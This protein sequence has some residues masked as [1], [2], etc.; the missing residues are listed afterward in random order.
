[1]TVH[2]LN[3]QVIQA[4]RAGGEVPGM[5]RDRLLLLT[6]TGRLSA[7]P[8]TVPLMYYPD[9]AAPVILA[10]DNGSPREPDWYRNLLADPL[11]H[12]ELDGDEFDAD[13]EVLEGAERERVWDAFAARYPFVIEHEQQAG[14]VIPLVA[15]GRATSS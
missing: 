8:R 3:D 14:R 5:H 4:F 13:A 11:V 2:E 7:E 15:L 12:V 9:D 1:M 10:S 6:T